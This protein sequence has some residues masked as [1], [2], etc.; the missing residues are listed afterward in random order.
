MNLAAFDTKY[1]NIQ[2]NSQIGI[3]PTVIN[4]GNATIWGGEAE[5]QALLGAGFS[6]NMGLGYTKAYYTYM[7]NV[8]DNGYSLTLNS[9]PER[10]P[11][12]PLPGATPAAVAQI[13]ATYRNGV[14]QLPKT[15]KFKS[16][17][18]PEYVT[19]LP[20]S[21]ALQ[22]NVDWTYVTTEYNDIGN[23]WELARPSM[24]LFNGS[25]T[26]KAPG[27]VWE[28]AVGGTNLSDKRFVVSGQNQGGVAVI[29]A[30]YN[31]PRQWYGTFRF[32]M[33][34]SK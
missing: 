8:G 25:I 28:F 16:S 32:N 14:C 15:P 6:M 17:V 29:D 30:S 3:S 13:A 34:G 1:K 33:G 18:G 2:L 19:N 7:N 10:D 26:Y 21:G 20:N 22:F 31:P 23:T 9:C 11:G 4:A 27:K 12:A 24:S 5:I